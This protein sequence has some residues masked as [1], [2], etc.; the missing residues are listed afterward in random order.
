MK[1]SESADGKSSTKE[2]D[3]STIAGTRKPTKAEGAAFAVEAR[4]RGFG[5]RVKDYGGTGG[6]VLELSTTFA[7]GD[8]N[9]YVTIENIAWALLSGVPRVAYGST[10]GSTSDGV[11]GHAALVSGRFVLA[12]S[13]VSKRF[14]NGVKS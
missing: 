4:N 2:H 13:G 5:V 10:W 8:A 12:T 14:A 7:P 11:G 3:M 1:C 6:V 9:D